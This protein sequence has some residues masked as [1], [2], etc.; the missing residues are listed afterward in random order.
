MQKLAGV[1]TLKAQA[2]A[3]TWTQQPCT[4]H[5]SQS[6][7]KEIQETTFHHLQIVKANSTN[8]HEANKHIPL[9]WMSLQN[10]AQVYQFDCKVNS[11]ARCYIM[12]LDIY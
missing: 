9:L 12:H 4:A 2:L 11:G 3:E 10:Y 8:K 6:L 1:H 7:Q 5:C